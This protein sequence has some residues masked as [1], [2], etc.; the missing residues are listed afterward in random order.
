MTSTQ[1]RTRRLVASA[2]LVAVVGVSAAC[3]GSDDAPSGSGTTAAE[4]P[5]EGSEAPEACA[6]P[7]PQAFTEPDLAEVTLSPDGFPEP[8][9]DATLCLTTSTVD[10]SQETAS[11]ATGATA[12]EILAGYE[13]ALGA[14]SPARDTDGVG[15]PILVAQDGDLT[16]QVTPQE[17]GFVLAFANV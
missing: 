15:R 17:G 7:F 11:Y 4:A 12:E 10:N 2:L 8:P 13:T 5:G 14:Y 3:S 9:F 6:E 16:I 1:A